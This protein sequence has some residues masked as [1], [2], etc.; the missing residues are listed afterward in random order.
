VWR[1]KK[2]QNAGG[3]LACSYDSAM[4]RTWIIVVSL[5]HA[6]RGVDLG[7]IMANHG[8][9]AP[10]ARMAAGDRVW[11]Y[12]PRTSYPNG[13]PLKAITV[14]GEITGAEPEPSDVIKGGFR[15]RANLRE[16]DP[17][18]LD[19]IRDWLPMTKLRFGCFELEPS[20]AGQ[21]EKLIPDG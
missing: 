7:F 1:S 21:I 18:P 17:V 15:R 19:L 6:R 9:R 2:G 8:K 12:S 20:A 13:G 14:V 10:L 4:P 11:I 5:E 16:I 3:G